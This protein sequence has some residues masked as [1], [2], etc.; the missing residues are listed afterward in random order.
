MTHSKTAL[1]PFLYHDF[2]HAADILL[3]ALRRHHPYILLLGESGSGKTTLLR[4]L[5]DKLDKRA[6]SVLYLC[7]G[8]PSPS[9]LA[10]VLADALHLPIRR[11]RAE[12]S[13]LLLSTLKNLPAKLLLWI[14]EAQLIADDTLHELRL[15]SEADL[16]GP[17]LFCVILAALP[18]LK[19]RLLAP[20]L[21]PLHRRISTRVRLRGLLHE[22]V[23]PF[24][25]HAL[26]EK[27]SQRFSA[28]ALSV[29][30]EQARAIPAIIK[31]HA[32]LCVDTCKNTKTTIDKQTVIDLLDS[33]DAA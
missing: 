1:T 20:D 10:R 9:A 22:E 26:G 23:G 15:L 25:D 12:T 21:F 19:E 4:H 3:A 18:Q 30:F 33:I 27:T 6:F 31:S 8:R 5:Q 24:I 13:R 32:A 14:D 11:T 29:M 17:P 16:D 7:H 28:E 2:R